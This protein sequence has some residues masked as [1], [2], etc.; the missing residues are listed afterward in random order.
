MIKYI[1][2]VLLLLNVIQA[3]EFKTKYLFCTLVEETTNRSNVNYITE[4]TAKSRD[5]FNLN[6]V[7]EETEFKMEGLFPVDYKMTNGN[8]YDIYN[9]Y[10]LSIYYKAGV[11]LMIEQTTEGR[12]Y[13]RYFDCRKRK[14]TIQERAENLKKKW[15]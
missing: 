4:R 1:F 6:T 5:M 15:F 7:I 2:F 14:L 10:N 8:G 11:R 3:K 12:E 13:T 9:F